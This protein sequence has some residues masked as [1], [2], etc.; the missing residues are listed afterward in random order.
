[1]NV[2]FIFCLFSFVVT[3]VTGSEGMMSGTLQRCK[4]SKRSWRSLW[5]LLKDK[6]LY[7]YPQPEVLH[8]VTFLH[9]LTCNMQFLISPLCL[10]L[11]YK[12][13]VACETLPLLGFSVRPEVEGESSM[14]QLYHN[15][16]LFYTFRAQDSNTALRLKHINFT[17]TVHIKMYMIYK[18][19]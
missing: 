8:T 1:M 14:F 17:F 16:T 5:F 11:I 3:K 10:F 13:R 15:S 6:V 2:F 19:E 9:T 7:T 12:E 4:N 18:N